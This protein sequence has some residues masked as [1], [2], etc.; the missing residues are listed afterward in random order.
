MN[1]RPTTIRADD[2]DSEEPQESERKQRGSV[3]PQ[4]LNANPII[5]TIQRRLQDHGVLISIRLLDSPPATDEFL[6]NVFGAEVTLEL[7]KMVLRALIDH[8]KTFKKTIALA[9]F[10]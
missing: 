3:K 7:G 8:D 4:K 9:A 6:N 10:L 1:K 2:D 5:A